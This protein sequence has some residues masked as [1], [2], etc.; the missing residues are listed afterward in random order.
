M[1]P[2]LQFSIPSRL[3]WQA[4]LFPLAPPFVL[5]LACGQDTGIF[6]CVICLL[7]TGPQSRLQ[8]HPGIPSLPLAI[9]WDWE[10][11]VAG[12]LHASPWPHACSFPCLNTEEAPELGGE[13]PRLALPW[14]WGRFLLLPPW[15]YS[16]SSPLAD[17]Q[18]A[19]SPPKV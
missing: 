11:K 6:F 5:L 19:S 14:Q 9:P 4:C 8:R 7:L 13:A 15:C 3:R 17:R 10:A 18:G 1:P 2:L 12:L 16:C